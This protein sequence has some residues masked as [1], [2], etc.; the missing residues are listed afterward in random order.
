[1]QISNLNAFQNTYW[2]LNI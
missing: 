1:M 2:Y